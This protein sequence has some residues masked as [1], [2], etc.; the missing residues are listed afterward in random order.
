M[1]VFGPQ[2]VL[3]TRSKS[4]AFARFTVPDTSARHL[5]VIE[6]GGANGELKRVTSATIWLNGMRVVGPREFRRS[7]RRIEVPVRARRHNLLWIHVHGKPGSGVTYRIE[8]KDRRPPLISN[9][10]PGDG[11]VV[12]DPE[13]TLTVTASDVLSGVA[14]VTCN[15]VES[16]FVDPDYACTVPLLPGSNAI[17][18]VA[19]DGCGNSSARVV[20]VTFDPPPDVTITSPADGDV[21][22][23]NPVIVTGTVDDPAAS[24]TVNGVPAQ[25]GADFTVALTLPAGENTITAVARDAIGGE[26]TDSVEVTLIPGPGPTVTISAPEQ[27]FVTGG[28]ENRF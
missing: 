13:I 26:G 2:D 19:T 6:N 28:P 1:T 15:G 22:T 23:G 9:V 5:L 8:A 21:L 20:H 27:D 12:S 24:V 10:E 16:T 25:S 11:T 18:V 17:E 14:S 7:K 3:R 4:W